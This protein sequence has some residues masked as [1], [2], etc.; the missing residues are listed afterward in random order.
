LTVAQDPGPYPASPYL[1]RRKA[2]A[3]QYRE[4]QDV[5]SPRAKELHR[6]CVCLIE[7][8][9]AMDGYQQ[10]VDATQDEGL[11]KIMEHNRDEEKEHAC[12]LLEWIRRNDENFAK[13]IKVYLY[14]EEP[15]LDG[16]YSIS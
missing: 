6:A 9:E 11:R 16:P 12:M 10:R 1:E 3:E 14:P 8:I 7:E 4:P 13:K 5:L 15:E 2:M